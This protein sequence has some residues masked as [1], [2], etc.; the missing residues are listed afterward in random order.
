ML[1]GMIIIICPL[2]YE[3][4]VVCAFITKEKLCVCV[5]LDLC[6]FVCILSGW[7]LFDREIFQMFVFV[8]M[9]FCAVYVCVCVWTCVPLC[10][11][12]EWLFAL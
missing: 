4:K 5:C 12:F 1:F 9:S 8:F 10:L 11:Y 6:L 7:L 3:M 2:Y